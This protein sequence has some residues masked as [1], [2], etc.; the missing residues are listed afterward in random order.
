MDDYKWQRMVARGLL[1]KAEVAKLQLQGSPGV[2]VYSWAIK[3]L[4]CNHA[5]ASLER[6]KTNG[7]T[8]SDNSDNNRRRGSAEEGEEALRELNMW[9]SGQLPLQLNMEACIGGTRGL[10]AK[11]IAYTYA[12]FPSV[13]FQAVHVSVNVSHA[14]N[15]CSCKTVDSRRDTFITN[16]LTRSPLECDQRMKLI[17]RCT[18]S[19]PCTAQV[20]ASLRRWTSRAAASSTHRGPQTTRTP[21]HRTY[22][23]LVGQPPSP[24]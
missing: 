6:N 18:C 14:N 17:R 19:V 16:S 24:R 3:I 5:P 12:Q 2:I 1:T 8:R 20:T 11:Q 22:V 15:S 7:G 4:R 23:G 13:Y 10:A 21:R 9:A